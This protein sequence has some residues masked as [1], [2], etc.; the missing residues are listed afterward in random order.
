[1]SRA[2]SRARTVVFGASHWHVPL[3]VGAMAEHHDVVAV[4]DDDPGAARS[5][6][7]AL[8]GVPVRTHAELLDTEGLDLAYVFGPHDEMAALC[9]GLVERG[10]PFVVEKPLGTSLEE[11]ERVRAAAAAAGVPA[12]V[13]LTQR[14]GP[15]ETWLAQ[16][17]TPVYE[18]ASFVAG[19]PARY[20]R[21]G[22]PWMLDPARAG[23]GCLANLGPHFVDLFLQRA[24]ETT[25][26]VET[27]LRSTL[28]GLA[29]EDHATLVL[30]T[31][32][33]REAIIEVG[34]AYPDAPAKRYC[35]FTTVGSLGYAAIDTDGAAT[36]VSVDGTTASDVIVVDSDPQYAPFV[37]RVA[38]TLDSGFAG[39]PSLDDLAHTMAII[40][41][42]YA[43]ARQ[44]GGHHG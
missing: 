38:E 28:H 8:G 13:P 24:H 7:D 34:Y 32:A 2:R 44:T 20:L 11:L 4:G 10:V 9:L 30:R 31:P 5:V 15:I 1:M 36:F 16:A 6:A 41:T 23:G 40:W 17:G 12:T 35:S 18:R 21:N 25:A 43:D 42:A 39:M 19:P 22:N 14:G 29:I 3:Y 37:G 26:A 27:S 33:G